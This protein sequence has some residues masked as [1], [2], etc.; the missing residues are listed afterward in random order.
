LLNGTIEFVMQDL[1]E[2]SGMT[3][4]AAN[5]VLV[6]KLDEIRNFIDPRFHQASV[7]CE[8]LD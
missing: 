1:T 3:T 5:H 6:D 7:F 8:Y 2:K 4:K